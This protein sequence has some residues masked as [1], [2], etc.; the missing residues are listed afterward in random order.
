MGDSP[1]VAVGDYRGLAVSVL[2]DP[3]SRLS[4]VSRQFLARR[5]EL[6]QSTRVVNSVVFATVHGPLRLP[7]ATGTFTSSHDIA[8]LMLSRYDVLL[9][10]DWLLS[11]CL[12]VTP[13]GL[14]NP[15]PHFTP[16]HLQTWTNRYDGAIPLFFVVIAR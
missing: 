4:V 7:C 16:S 6:P 9:G 5:P 2:V 15:G 3:G 8:V 11:T 1:L 14:M 10:C 12:A 13:Q